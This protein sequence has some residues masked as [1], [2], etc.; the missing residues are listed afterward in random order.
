MNEGVVSAVLDDPR[1]YALLEWLETSALGEMLRDSGVWTYGL[2]NLAHILGIATLFGSVLLLDLR[3]LGA[4]R[5]LPLALLARATVPLAATG[6]VIAFVSGVSMLSFNATEYA[7][8]PFLYV[9]LP[10]IAFALLNVALVQRLGPWRRALAGE[11]P[12]GRDRGLLAAVGAVSL[13]TWLG[14]VSRGRMIG[15]W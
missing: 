10:L 3:L 15:Y 14:V 11:D 6:F 1:A 12:T 7:G 13:V 5:A 8:N 4:W 2:I 9:K